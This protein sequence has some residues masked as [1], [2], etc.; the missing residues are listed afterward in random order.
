M[1]QDEK[2]GEVSFEGS[3][4]LEPRHFFSQPSIVLVDNVVET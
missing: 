3:G 1:I 2:T 4:T